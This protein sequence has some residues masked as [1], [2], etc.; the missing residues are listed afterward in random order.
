MSDLFGSM[1]KSVTIYK[2]KKLICVW[3]SY[4]KSAEWIMMCSLV[5]CLQ[6]VALNRS[7]FGIHTSPVSLRLHDE[8]SYCLA[9]AL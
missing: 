1:Q 5:Y 7:V 2:G 3:H 6:S 4:N 9:V 8:S